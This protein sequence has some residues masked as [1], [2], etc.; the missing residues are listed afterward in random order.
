MFNRALCCINPNPM[1]KGVMEDV[2]FV[3]ASVL[4]LHLT[5][6]HQRE[7]SDL[8]SDNLLNIVSKIAFSKLIKD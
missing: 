3:G 6:S 1:M 8:N 2:I 7:C 4:A 5:R